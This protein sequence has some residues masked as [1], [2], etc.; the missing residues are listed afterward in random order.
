M[1]EKHKKLKDKHNDN[2]SGKCLAAMIQYVI[3]GEEL[4]IKMSGQ[5]LPVTG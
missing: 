3:K 1:K 2:Q 5:T 4:Y